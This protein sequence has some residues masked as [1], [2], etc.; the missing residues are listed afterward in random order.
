MA[1]WSPRN[2]L[3]VGAKSYKMQTKHLKWNFDS[4]QSGILNSFIWDIGDHSIKIKQPKKCR[5]LN[6]I[7]Q[8]QISSLNGNLRR[9]RKTHKIGRNAQLHSSHKFS[10]RFWPL[11]PDY[12]SG[13]EGLQDRK[14]M[15]SNELDRDSV[16]IGAE[17]PNNIFFFLTKKP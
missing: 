5:F 16:Y 8:F 6:F 7:L 9:V 4:L 14:L 15:P 10:R 2:T 17:N 12:N 11:P 1:V 3:L 13:T